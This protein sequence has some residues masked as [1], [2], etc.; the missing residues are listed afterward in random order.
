MANKAEIKDE[1]FIQL[2]ARIKELRKEK[3]IS[4]ENLAASAQTNPVYISRIESGKQ[5][6]SIHTLDKLA[7]AMNVPIYAFFLYGTEQ[8]LFNIA[9]RINELT[10]SN[11]KGYQKDWGQLL[12]MIQEAI[13]E[14]MKKEL[15]ISSGY[16]GTTGLAMVAE[17]S[18]ASSAQY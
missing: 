12:I 13:L 8:H 7:K 11:V 4:Q 10:M 6:P 3:R 17:K 15:L 5:K 2:G 16:A 18:G 14:E 1:L 9:A